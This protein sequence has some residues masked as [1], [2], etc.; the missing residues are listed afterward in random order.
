MYAFEEDRETPAAHDVVV[1]GGGAAGLSAALFT[2]R[3]GLDTVV[4]D[5]GKSAIRQCAHLENYLG[6]PGGVA[7]ETFLELGRT[8]VREEGVAVRDERVT[9]VVPAAEDDGTAAGL[10]VETTDGGTTAA[11]VVAASAYDGEFL[12]DGLDRTEEGFAETADGSGRTDREG[13][14]VTGWMADGGVHQAAVNV[15]RGAQVG[16]GLVRDE[17]V[18]RGY[19]PDLADH[20]VDWVV[21]EGRYGGEGW[22]ASIRSFLAE[23]AP[24]DATD[25]EFEALFD[26]VSEA[27]LDRQ[28]GAEERARRVERGERLLLEHL[29]DD[30]IRAYLA[31]REG[32]DDDRDGADDAGRADPAAD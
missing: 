13:L 15:G 7:P 21:H 20:Y 9:A 30:T 16:V 3:A 26:A 32:T 12:P 22:D 19:W 14:Y 31:D 28:V 8:Q 29:D 17:M 11:R 23:N 10:R 1:A 4:F 18:A 2:A 25:E 27:F 6:F 5:G 24:E